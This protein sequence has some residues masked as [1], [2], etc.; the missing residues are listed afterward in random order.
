MRIDC[1]HL[2]LNLNLY[3]NNDI[4]KLIMFVSLFKEFCWFLGI[5]ILLYTESSKVKLSFSK[6][7]CY[8]HKKQS[9][10]TINMKSQIVRE[11]DWRLKLQCIGIHKV[12]IEGE[13]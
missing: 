4:Q 8:R 11:S 6:A 10:C 3:G 7:I 13:S 1:H 5:L 2:T 9:K 12:T